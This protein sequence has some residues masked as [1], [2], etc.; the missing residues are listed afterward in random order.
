MSEYQWWHERCD[1]LGITTSV[2]VKLLHAEQSPHQ[3]V[4][5][6]DHQSFGRMLV[7]DGYIQASQADEFIYH[8]MAVHV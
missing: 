3:R 8:E 4:E 2:E 5:I 6:Y 1:G 7:L